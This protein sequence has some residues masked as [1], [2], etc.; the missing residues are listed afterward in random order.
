MHHYAMER[1]VLY[2]QDY[3]GVTSGSKSRDIEDSQNGDKAWS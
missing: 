2:H 1:K 3:P